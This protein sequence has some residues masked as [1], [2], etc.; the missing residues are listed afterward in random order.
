MEFEGTIFVDN[1][2]TLEDV[3]SQMQ[4][5][6][7][8]IL[9]VID[10]CIFQSYESLDKL[11]ITLEMDNLL[12][13]KKT[14]LLIYGYRCRDTD[15]YYSFFLKNVDKYLKDVSER[16]IIGRVVKMSTPPNTRGSFQKSRSK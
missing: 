7:K 14:G 1:G 8:N 12:E 5:S 13:N 2:F 4:H 15:S 10:G 6:T 9:C 3:I 11:P 16:E